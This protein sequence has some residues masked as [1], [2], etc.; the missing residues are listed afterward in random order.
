[1]A[2]AD[3]VIYI[4]ESDEN[5]AVLAIDNQTG[6]VSTVIPSHDSE[7]GVSETGSVVDGIIHSAEFSVSFHY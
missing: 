7:T 2:L 5:N 3:S 6:R 1:M 4:L